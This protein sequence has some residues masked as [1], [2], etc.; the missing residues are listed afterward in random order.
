MTWHASAEITIPIR[1]DATWGAVAEAVRPLTDYLGVPLLS[2]ARNETNFA[3]FTAD[4]DLH[5]RISRKVDQAFF[6]TVLTPVAGRLGALAARPF[7]FEVFDADANED[8]PAIFKASGGRETVL[9]QL[10]PVQSLI[11]AALA[12]AGSTNDQT[13]RANLLEAIGR[14]TQVRTTQAWTVEDVTEN[15]A[16]MDPP[17]DLSEGD[18][19]ALLYGM[20]ELSETMGI[21]SERFDR[22]VAEGLQAFDKEDATNQAS[23]P[24][25]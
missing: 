24:R 17:R 16:A 22:C 11:D 9:P 2:S 19:R 8:A 10:E 5:A 18:A 13:A 3:A 7:S 25:G 6:K 1:S 23:A 4:G 20:A 12:A 21:E 15:A 14:F